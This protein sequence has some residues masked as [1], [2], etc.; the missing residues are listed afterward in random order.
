MGNTNQDPIWGSLFGRG[1]PQPG[2]WSG[3]ADEKAPPIQGHDVDGVF[4]VRLSDVV[5]LLEANRV[6][7]KAIA[8]FKAQLE[9][10]RS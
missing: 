10:F 2:G 8:R 6:L 3:G 7:P 1:R 9:K 4:Y 5:D